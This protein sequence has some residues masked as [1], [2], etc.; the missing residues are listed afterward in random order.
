M[1]TSENLR[2]T[3]AFRGYKKRPVACNRLTHD[4]FCYYD[5]LLT[6]Y[7]NNK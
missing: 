6:V 3:D 7:Q 1:K 5:R 4:T 2:V